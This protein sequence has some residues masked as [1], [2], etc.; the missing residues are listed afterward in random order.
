MSAS[1]GVDRTTLR[2]YIAAAAAGIASQLNGLQLDEAGEAGPGVLR[3]GH[4]VL[5]FPPGVAG[6]PCHRVIIPRPRLR[7]RAH[8]AAAARDLVSGPAPMGPRFCARSLPPRHPASRL[9]DLD[10]TVDGQMNFRCNTGHSASAVAVFSGS[11]QG[12]CG[13]AA[14]RPVDNRRQMR[15]AARQDNGLPRLPPAA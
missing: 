14:S 13:Q 10:T 9:R 6:S 8:Q 3:I 12:A 5:P 4:R 15:P 1:L 2:K 11:Q 7:Q